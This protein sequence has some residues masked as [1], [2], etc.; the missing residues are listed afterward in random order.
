[1]A[2]QLP[3]LSRTYALQYTGNVIS[4]QKD[5][6]AI[7]S[8]NEPDMCDILKVITYSNISAWDMD[9]QNC[10][11]ETLLSWALNEFEKLSNDKQAGSKRLKVASSLV[12]WA[13]RIAELN[14]G[15]VKFLSSNSD[16]ASTIIQHMLGLYIN[17]IR[18]TDD[19]S[20]KKET[21]ILQASLNRFFLPLVEVL[22]TR[23]DHPVL[24]LPAW[25]QC[26]KSLKSFKP[27]SVHTARNT[28]AIFVNN[29]FLRVRDPRQVNLLMQL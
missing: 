4:L 27:S 3:T 10:F 25:D 5:N 2:S 24:S 21:D 11:L 19:D 8:D 23:A 16:K 18:L 22:H 15:L 6:V 29:V 13:A 14:S 9:S 26:Y 12:F 20:L 7:S 1:M 17:S 28:M